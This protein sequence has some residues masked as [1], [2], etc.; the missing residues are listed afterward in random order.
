MDCQVNHAQMG[1]ASAAA[2]QEFVYQLPMNMLPHF[3]QLFTYLD[4]HTQELGIFTYGISMTTLD[5]VFLRLADLNEDKSKS[6]TSVE[7][8][9]V[10]DGS[11]VSN[12]PPTRERLVS[13]DGDDVALIDM[14]EDDGG[15]GNG[16]AKLRVMIFMMMMLRFKQAMRNKMALIFQIFVPCILLVAGLHIT[17]GT[18]DASPFDVARIPLTPT[19]PLSSPVPFIDNRNNVSTTLGRLNKTLGWQLR[20]VAG[21][22]T[23]Q[24]FDKHPDDPKI[25]LQFDAS[26]TTVVFD[27]TSAHS[28]MLPSYLNALHN[29]ECPAQ[30]SI[31]AFLQPLPFKTGAVFDATTFNA[32]LYIG[33]ALS[34]IP[35]GFVI[36]LVR[37]RKLKTKHQ[38]FTAGV[39]MPAYFIA[40]LLMDILL[41]AI[42]V[43]VGLILMLAMDVTPLYA[44]CTSL[45]CKLW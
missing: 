13:N 31:S 24:Y 8:R 20:R 22:T 45:A 15:D 42:P 35:G 7:L 9:S 43:S 18:S 38:L 2:N 12:M 11:H 17:L 16:A 23:A 39:P 37:D 26:K 28:D 3:A 14:H 36:D 34:I 40:Y 44:A 30:H 41:M 21:E 29:S 32:V 1:M 10:S 25:F 19:T 5:E 33:I 4:N 27:P 6:E